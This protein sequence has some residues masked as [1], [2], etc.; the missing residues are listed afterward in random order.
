MLAARILF[1]SWIYLTEFDEFVVILAAHFRDKC[2]LVA[3]IL[4]CGAMPV[5]IVA[6]FAH[7]A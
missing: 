7:E 3:D 6:N 1:S 5:S 2:A 4:R